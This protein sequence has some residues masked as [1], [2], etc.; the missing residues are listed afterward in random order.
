VFALSKFG[1][2]IE[3]IMIMMGIAEMIANLMVGPIKMRFK[4]I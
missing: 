3:E 2:D 1:A 4:R